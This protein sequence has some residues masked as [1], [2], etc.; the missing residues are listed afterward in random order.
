MHRGEK[1]DANIGW[2]GRDIDME[3]E[4]L[5]SE[6]GSRKGRERERDSYRYI[7]REC[8][9]VWGL[10]WRD[11]EGETMGDRDIDGGGRDVLTLK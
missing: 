3:R 10:R 4:V 2:G 5:E 7:W 1:R 6:R 9:Y 11:K 8:V